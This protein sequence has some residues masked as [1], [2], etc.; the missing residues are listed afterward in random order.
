MVEFYRQLGDPSLSK[1]QAL[2][3]AQLKLQQDE[4][5]SHPFYWSPFLMINNWL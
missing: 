4:R 1:A 2:Q 3:H 5:F